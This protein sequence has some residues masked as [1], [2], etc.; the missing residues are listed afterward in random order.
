M[1]KGKGTGEGWGEGEGKGKG[2][3]GNWKGGLC[4]SCDF[5]PK[6]FIGCC[7]PP[8]GNYFIAE[9]TGDD[10]VIKYIGFLDFFGGGGIFSAAAQMIMRGKIREREGIEGSVAGDCLAAF[11]CLSCSTCQMSNHLG[12]DWQDKSL[13]RIKIVSSHFASMIEYW[14]WNQIKFN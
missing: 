13:R 4:S 8:L 9:R 7:L 6:C 3:G 14:V 2:Q 5:T 10:D 11:C 12:L 1:G